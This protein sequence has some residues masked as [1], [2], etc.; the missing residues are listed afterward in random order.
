MNLLAVSASRPMDSGS[1]LSGQIRW[2]IIALPISGSPA[3]T[4]A[5][6]ACWSGMARRP[7]GTD[8]L[9]P[10][11]RAFCVSLRLANDHASGRSMR[12]EFARCIYE[13][14]LGGGCSRAD[15]NHL[16]LTTHTSGLRR[17]CADK[18]DLHL[19]GCVSGF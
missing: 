15:M 14:S 12:V 17:Q 19:E 18:I 3:S 13:S 1:C 9:S 6:V 10:V 8:A 11:A 16:R 7:H 2:M 5:M 4:V